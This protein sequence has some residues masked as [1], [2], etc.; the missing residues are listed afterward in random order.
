MQSSC[1]LGTGETLWCSS[2]EAQGMYTGDGLK[3]VVDVFNEQW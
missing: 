2:P 1:R 3:Y